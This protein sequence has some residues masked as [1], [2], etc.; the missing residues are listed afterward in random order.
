[1][2]SLNIVPLGGL[3]EIGKNMLSVEYGRNILIVDAGIMFPE[4][5]MPGVD[6]IIPDWDYLRDKKE[7]ARDRDYPRSPG[8]HRRAASLSARV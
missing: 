2:A 8:S 4:T 5:G 6:Y 7:L 3:G 1:M